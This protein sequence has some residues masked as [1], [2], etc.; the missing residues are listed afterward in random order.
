VERGPAEPIRPDIRNLPGTEYLDVLS[1]DVYGNDFD[2][3]YRRPLAL[4]EGKPIALGEVGSPPS[5]DV[6]EAQPKW[7]Y[8]VVWAG[9][10]RGTSRADH[11]RLAGDPRVLFMEDPAYLE[12]TAAYRQA[13]GLAPLTMDRAADFSGA[14]RLNEYESTVPYF[15]SE[16]ALGGHHAEGVV[17]VASASIVEWADGSNG[18]RC[19]STA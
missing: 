13:S 12:G 4:S 7:V 10:V 17:R 11:E 19:H 2:Q 9:M 5:P 18:K 3:S 14:W 15:E 16:R 1:L 6:L 8:W